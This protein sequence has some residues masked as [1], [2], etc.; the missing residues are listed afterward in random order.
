M[1]SISEPYNFQKGSRVLTNINL[2]KKPAYQT[3]TNLRSISIAVVD[4]GVVTL[5]QPLP[6]AGDEQRLGWYQHSNHYG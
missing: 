4:A 6:K 2:F 1:K 3:E 5:I